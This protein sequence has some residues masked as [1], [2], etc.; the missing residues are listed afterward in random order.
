MPPRAGE[1]LPCQSPAAPRQAC[2]LSATS[3]WGTAGSRPSRFA[4]GPGSEQAVP[5][6]WCTQRLLV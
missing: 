6:S 5:L 4:P 2:R 3:R 1:Q